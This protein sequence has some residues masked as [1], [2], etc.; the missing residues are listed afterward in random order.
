M[1]SFTNT[2]FVEY[3]KGLDFYELEDVAEFTHLYWKQFVENPDD[4]NSK[5]RYN[6]CMSVYGHLF[7]QYTRAAIELRK[8]YEDNKTQVTS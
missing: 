6:A 4:Y 2:E 3:I 5:F 1:M 7:L 8:S